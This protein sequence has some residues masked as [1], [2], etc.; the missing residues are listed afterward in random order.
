M[1]L[2]YGLEYAGA[3]K[4]VRRDWGA[5]VLTVV[6]LLGLAALCVWLVGCERG[7]ALDAGCWLL[8]FRIQNLASS[9]QPLVAMATPLVPVV[10]GI[11]ALVM[12]GLMCWAICAVRK[13][14]LW[15][16]A[17]R[18]ERR[19]K[20]QDPLAEVSDGLNC[21]EMHRILSSVLAEARE[22]RRLVMGVSPPLEDATARLHVL[23]GCV[24]GLCER[25][26]PEITER[27]VR[28]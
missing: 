24:D 10:V 14:E 2:R 3:R 12:T 5:T 26:Q 20:A 1:N 27:E 21:D 23:I 22:V 7:A 13:N 18:E 28:V 8:D 11:T 9:N 6:T 16:M 17:L 19:L 25:L 4:R 15:I